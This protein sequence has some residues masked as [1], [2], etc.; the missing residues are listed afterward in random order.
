MNWSKKRLPD[1]PEMNC[2]ICESEL[3]NSGLSEGRVE[4]DSN[5][6]KGKEIVNFFRLQSIAV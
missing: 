1:S 4:R 2:H 6:E 5:L 3:E